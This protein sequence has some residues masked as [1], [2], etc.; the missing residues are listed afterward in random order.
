MPQ[1]GIKSAFLSKKN[2]TVTNNRWLENS[3]FR[4]FGCPRWL[5]LP[6]AHQNVIESTCSL[7][8]LYATVWHQKYFFDNF[9]FKSD[10]ETVGLAYQLLSVFWLP[11]IAR[12]TQGTPKCYKKHIKYMPMLCQIWQFF[13]QLPGLIAK[14]PNFEAKS[15]IPKQICSG[16]IRGA[17]NH[18]PWYPPG[19][20]YGPAV[21][22]GW[23]GYALGA[24]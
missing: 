22:A 8:Q 9:C 18:T 21:K 4:F 15:P 2:P 6:G 12:T 10:K 14:K 13:C 20:P 17:H 7:C 16:A 11:Q 23:F 1:C 24:L 5:E 19:T 3:Y